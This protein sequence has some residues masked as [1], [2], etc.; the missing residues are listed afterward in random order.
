MISY[1][2]TCSEIDEEADVDVKVSRQREIIIA[3]DNFHLVDNT[4]QRSKVLTFLRVV[5]CELKISLPRL[6][7]LFLI[8]LFNSFEGEEHDKTYF[9]FLS[10]FFYRGTV[11]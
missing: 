7:T 6:F 10:S 4:L 1:Q 5:T 8:F 2:G 11:L 9:S 3:R